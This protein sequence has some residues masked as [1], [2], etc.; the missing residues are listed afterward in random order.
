MK[1][2]LLILAAGIGSRYGSLKQVDPVGPS[3]ETI[4]DYSVYDA[5]RAG[6]GKIVFVI[7]KDI[8]KEFR[9]LI[10]PKYEG[11]INIEFAFQEV[12]SLPAGF[13]APAGRSKPWGT[14]HAVLVAKD[15]V[16]EPFAIINADD[17]YGPEAFSTISEFL[18]GDPE[19]LQS[20]Y[21][22]VG[23]LLKNTLSDHGF[24]SRGICKTDKNGL[25]VEVVERTA[26]RSIGGWPAYS[27]D[28]KET[29]Y[30]P[31]DAIVSMNF[32]G[33]MPSGFNLLEGLFTD[34]L[35]QKG[36]DQKSEFYLSSAVDDLIKAEKLKVRVLRSP[37]QW[38]GVTYKEDKAMVVERLNSMVNNGIYPPA[39]W[40]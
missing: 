32:W 37:A 4:M 26:I 7:R 13:T 30:L 31:T 3:G 6:F 18:Q 33:F 1:P 12:E 36:Q 14:G 16:K 39:L 29:I 35:S 10:L 2:T 21:A 28:E 38:F 9:E 22:M 34:F 24:V 40:I 17:F 25:L 19:T 5:I 27:E 23:Y 11:K 20:H 15:V 8:E